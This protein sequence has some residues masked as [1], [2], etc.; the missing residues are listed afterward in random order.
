MHLKKS[1]LRF[2]CKTVSVFLAIFAMS[3]IARAQD[4]QVIDKVIA[5]VGKNIVLLSD[6]EAQYI[7]YVAQYP[8]AVKQGRCKVLEEILFNKL[9]LAQADKDSVVVSESQIDG[10]IERR[11]RYFI[12]QFGSEEKFSEFYGKTIDEFKSELR[13]DVHN[14]LLAQ[15]MQSKIT[16]DVAVSPAEV[17]TYFSQIP[18]DSIPLINAEVEIAHIVKK[19]PVSEEA[20]KIA[21]EKLESIR[22]KVIKDTSQFITQAVLYSED[23]GSSA[24]G[25]L[26]KNIQRGQF[27]PEFDAV[28]FQLNKGDISHVFETEYGYHF[29][30]LMDRRGEFIDVRHIL[31]APKVTPDDLVKAKIKLDSI[32]DLIM[33]DSIT[34]SDAAAIYSDDKDSKNSGGLIINPADGT[35]RFEMD[36]LSQIDPSIVFSVD[37][38]KVGEISKPVPMMTKDAKQAYRIILLKVRTSP[39]RANLIDDYQKIQAAA[40]MEKQQAE[41]MKWVRKKLKY[42]YVKID[43]SY[44]DCSFENNW[45]NNQNNQ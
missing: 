35:T 14:L 6:L 38:M 9:L 4:G 32:Y 42:T 26:Y 41:V 11:L 36:Q 44:K 40:L 39:H 29:M 2:I 12:S 22:L 31:M 18:D 23:P 33:K 10:E 7:Q 30:Q 3:I 5:V 45:Y 8:E 37:N 17:K 21:K 25:G 15:T 19:P 43:D 34:F 13:D 24:K 20:K 1:K 28:A 16:S 27:V